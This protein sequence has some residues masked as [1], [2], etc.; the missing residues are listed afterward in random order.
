MSFLSVLSRFDPA[1]PRVDTLQSPEVEIPGFREALK[2]ICS[3]LDA[4]APSRCIKAQ[5]LQ[6]RCSERAAPTFRV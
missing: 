3:P 4:I 1:L 2:T 6:Q 5:S